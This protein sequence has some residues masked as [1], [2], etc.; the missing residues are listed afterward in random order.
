MFRLLN[1]KLCVDAFFSSW[2]LWGRFYFNLRTKNKF[3][4]TFETIWWGCLQELKIDHCKLKGNKAVENIAKLLKIPWTH[5]SGLVWDSENIT[6]H[7][8]FKTLYLNSSTISKRTFLLHF[9]YFAVRVSLL[10]W[11][12]YNNGRFCW[13]FK[14]T[15]RLLSRSFFFVWHFTATQHVT[16]L[17]SGTLFRLS[18]PSSIW[19]HTR[20]HINMDLITVARCYKA[21]S[22]WKHVRQ[23][24]CV[25]LL[26]KKGSN[27]T[28][29]LTRIGMD[30]SDSK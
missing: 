13:T 19:R 7:F 20:R 22:V 26:H 5:R 17:D 28:E 24:M 25:M 16:L 2:F 27:S 9:S 21:G 29:S 6:L 3:C 15:L 4:S 10:R 14:I 1:S 18:L 23:K 8:T 11:W 30:V 12:H